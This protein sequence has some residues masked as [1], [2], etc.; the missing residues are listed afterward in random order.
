MGVEFAA[1]RR[2]LSE[3]E[4]APLISSH[5]PGLDGLSRP[6]LVDL[7]RWLRGRQNRLRDL[8]QHRRRVHRGK[9]EPRG[10]AES[11]SDNR[12]SAKKQVFSRGL[13]RVNSRLADLVAREKRATATAGLRAALARKQAAAAHH[14]AGGDSDAGAM[15]NKS[16][17]KRRPII[18]GSRVGSTGR[19]NRVAQAKRDTR[20]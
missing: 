18:T 14:P 7:A 9:A 4:M 20:A 12:M 5:Y 2:L 13:K 16:T 17:S 1:E 3:E 8:M 19:A 6:E 15:S 10:G 11:C